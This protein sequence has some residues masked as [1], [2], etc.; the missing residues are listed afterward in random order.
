MCDKNNQKLNEMNTPLLTQYEEELKI[1]K[2]KLS[3][4]I[5]VQIV[6]LMFSLFGICYL[7]VLPFLNNKPSTEDTVCTSECRVVLVESIPKNLTYAEGAPSH[8]STFNTWMNLIQ[9]AKTKIDVASFYWTLRAQDVN[10]TE[11]PSTVDGETIYKELLKAG[12]TRNIDI[13]IAYNMP[14]TK[15][16]DWDVLDLVK[17][18]AVEARSLNFS[19]LMNGGI[20]HTKMLLVD[21]THFY[22]GSANIDFR[23]LAEVK[24]LGAAVYNCSCLAQDMAKIFEVYW[25]LGEKDAYVPSSWPQD[26]NTDYNFN[27]TM[28]VPFNNTNARV[29]LS[30]SPPSFCP[31]GRVSDIDAILH[32]IDRAK[33]FI[34]VAVMDYLPIIPEYRRGEA[35]QLFWP[36]I[37]DR[38]RKAAIERGVEVQI[39][40]SIWNH[41]S[42]KMLPYLRSFKVINEIGE[43]KVDVKLFRVPDDQRYI[44]YSRVNHNKYMVTDNA[45][46]IGTSNWDGSYFTLTGGVGLIVNNTHSTSND[47][48]SLQDQLRDVFNRDWE[49]KYAEELSI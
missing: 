10:V 27:N 16:P 15:F 39:L 45:A 6:I 14:S 34:K 23:S 35:E 12:T 13:R 30:S 20:L 19:R 22:V 2:K 11:S 8:V 48:N 46:Y 25:K 47:S 41:T 40:G 36:V 43:N 26:L 32:V 9:S 7:F 42:S 29:V 5:V 31:K 3:L 38:L 28:P 4:L 44:P 1:P 37:D 33:T 24:E 49:S 18:K 21:D 17:A